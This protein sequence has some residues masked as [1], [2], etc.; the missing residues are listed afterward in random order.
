MNRFGWIGGICA[1][2]LIAIA[3]PALAQGTAHFDHSK[4]GFP[5]T[6]THM[7]VEC[8]T[9][10]VNGR[11]QGTPRQ[12]VGCHNGTVAPGMPANHIPAQTTA[13]DT[14]HRNSISFA[15]APMNHA[16]ITSNCTACHNGQ[17]FYGVTPVSKPAAHVAIGQADCVSCHRSYVSFAGA[18]FVHPTNSS[19]QCYSCHGAG[20]GGAMKEAANHVPT[21]TTT[22]DAC[23]KSTA[24]GGFATFTMG[25]AGHTALGV[26]ATS[27]CT[28]CHMGNYLGVV[29]K[30]SSHVTTTPANQNCSASGCHTGFT[31]FSGASYTHTASSTGQCYTCHGT[32]SGG[33]M[34]EAANHVPTGSVSC[35]ACH[36]STKTGGFATFSMGTA[37]H[38]ALGVTMTSNCTSC[39]MGNYLGVAVKPSTHVATTPANQNCSASGCHNSFTSFA[40]ATYTHTASSSG[41][42]YTCHGT[43]SGGAMKQVSNHVPTGSVSCDACHTST[44]TGGFATFSMGSSGHSALGVSLTSDCTSCHIGSYLGVMVKPSTHIATTPANQNCS[45]SGCHASFTS[46]AGA[47]YTH[48]TSSSGQCYT[49]H[50]TGSG[51]AMKEAANHVP[52]G[53]VSCDACHKSTAV[54]GFATF[55][56]GSAGHTALGVSA[57]SDCTSCHMGNYLGVVVKPSS[58]VTTTPANQN[59]SASGCHTGFTS[60]SGASYTHTASSTGQCYTCHGTGSGGAMKEAANHVPTGSVSCDACHTSTKTGGFATFSM[61]TAGH[62]ALGVTMTS[63]CTSCHMGNYLGVA[64]KPS[65]H[66]ATT[67]ANQNCSASG[68]HNSFTSF[69]GATYTHTASSSGQCYTCHGTGSGGAMK[70]VSNHVPTGTVSCDA[71]HTSTKTG[72]FATFSMGASGHSALGVSLTS[73]CT[74]CHIGSYLGVT[75]KPTSHVATTPANQNCSA[76]GCHNSFTSFSGATYTHTSASSGQCYTCHGTGSGGAMKEVSNHV[77]T[78]SVSCDACHTSTSVGGFATFTMGSTGHSALGVSM[79]STCTSCHMGSYLGVV[80]K[81]STHV[82]TSPA[83]QNCSASGCH[84]SFTSF[85]GATYNHSGVVA[86]T[87]YSCHGTGKNGAMMEVS[88]HVPTG[89]VSCDACHKSKSIGG[90]ATFTMGSAGH[91]ALGVSTASNCTTCH[92]GSYLGVV[93][94]PTGHIATSPTNQNC[95]DCHKTFTSF[96]GASYSHPASASGNCYSCHGTGVGGAMKEAAKHVP[97]GTVSCDVCHKSTVSGGFA[98]FT[99]GNAGHAALGVVLSTSNCITCHSGAYLGTATFKPHP[100]KDKA[101]TANAN[102]C[103]Q[104]HKS[105]TKSPGD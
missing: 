84:S 72:G 26:S 38:T 57:T 8:V 23:H 24:V 10:H 58:H 13:C 76:S 14:C 65:T 87:C 102:Y 83:N 63:N 99:M 49:C 51:G 43:G 73:N 53:S 16:G 71:C 92:M 22:C 88:K 36:T 93:V 91:T 37:G 34:K 62:T 64:V 18:A 42:C 81:P 45:A 31:S 7:T 39:H 32:G 89:T 97:T 21:G 78:G 86:G 4:T 77:P 41:Q 28:S 35:D 11:L 69:A 2:I 52:T 66:V 67:P 50:G 29:V 5:L 19:G 56:M 20:V 40:G 12:C 104:C 70:Q 48:T 27:D 101:T 68:C 15:G 9:C 79:T 80:V 55:T 44:K 17:T 59:C 47:T 105:F 60:F 95:Y 90:F 74:S 94:K 1:V 98:S 82:T 25:S 96:A 6:G 85:A 100:G 75:V 103:G 33:A 54:G 3:V 46:F 61:G 30:P